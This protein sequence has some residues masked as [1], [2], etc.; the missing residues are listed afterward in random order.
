V[1]SKVDCHIGQK[2]RQLR[3]VA[4]LTLPQLGAKIGVSAH[5]INKYETGVNRI[6]ASRMWAFATSLGVPISFFFEGLGDCGRDESNMP[7]D[8]LASREVYEFLRVY[9]TISV[10]QRR[11]LFELV[12]ALS[13]EG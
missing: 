12:R 1:T 8:A 11:K 10:A 5:Q 4:G 13:N 3:W 6:S 9:S 2:L 7:R